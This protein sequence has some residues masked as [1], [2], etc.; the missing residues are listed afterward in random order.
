MTWRVLIEICRVGLVW[1]L[2]LIML[3]G[4]LE[5]V[6]KE[7]LLSVLFK[8]VVIGLTFQKLSW[9]TRSWQDHYQCVYLGLALEGHLV[10]ALFEVDKNG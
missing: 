10:M 6:R 3:Q 7:E 8:E 5:L 4:R 9:F 1:F 2:I